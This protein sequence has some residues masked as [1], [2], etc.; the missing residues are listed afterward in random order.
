MAE[1]HSAVV[2]AR[3]LVGAALAACAAYDRPDLASRL[4]R[5]RA[6]LDDPATHVVVAGEFKQGKSSLVN[7]LVGASVCP[8]DDDVATALPTSVRHGAEPAAALVL[9][10]EPPLAEPLPLDAVRDHVVEREPAPSPRPDGRRPVGVEVRLPR[11]LLAGGLVLVDTPGLGGLGSV[12]AAATLAAACAADAVLFVTD[13]SAELTASEVDYLHRLRELCGTVVVVLTKTDVSPGW[14][15]VLDLDAAHLRARGPGDVP[16]VA[17]SSALRVRA[18]RTGD[19]A[20]AEES[21]YADLLGLLAGQ[22]RTA[23]G[24]TAGGRTAGG[25]GADG[26]VRAARHAAAEVVAVCRLLAVRFDGER[27]A[28]ADPAATRAVVADLERTRARVDELRSAA[29]RWNQTLSDGIADLTADVEHDLRGRIRRVVADADTAIA[30]GDPGEGWPQF[31][32]WLR[33]RIGHELVAGYG[34]M[35]ERADALA[36]TVA[37]HF[38]E[39]SGADLAGVPV[40]DPTPLVRQIEVLAD[41]ELERMSA[42][43]QTLVALRG[44][45]SGILMFT[46]LPSLVGLTG[47]APIAV[48]VGLLLG[49]S[50]LRE[51]KRRRLQQRRTQARGAVRT[52]CDE[53]QFVLGKDSRDTLRRVQR[54]L[55][56]HYTARAEELN[57]TTSEA[58]AA[59]QDAARRD[60]SGRA[61]RLRD[62]EAELARLDGLATKAE[63]LVHNGSAA[64]AVAP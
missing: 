54:T 44:S 30:D 9:D 11:P 49:R 35:R 20:L 22:G 5:A 47:L 48:P 46:M 42:R 24:R 31:E 55:R 10:G 40:H 53:V 61:A 36:G 15:R 23:G 4:D 59:A 3:T 27:A 56:D 51:E 12:H 6:R 7:A 17:V 45:Y 25:I 1:Q 33:A 19:A 60:E 38:R 13:A 43:S 29:A 62:L 41:V 39:A 58:L 37:E 14:R 16:L 63:A 21:G 57:R 52:Y 8:V 32:A 2:S 28:L 18:L 26:A 34:W 50:Q 64:K